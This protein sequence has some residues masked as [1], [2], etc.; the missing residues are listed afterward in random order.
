MTSQIANVSLSPQQIAAA[1]EIKNWYERGKEEG[2]E[3]KPI[4]R[5]FGYAG[6]GKTT[7][8]RFITE[9]L[10]IAEDILFAAYTGKAAMVMRKHGLPARTIHS[11]IYEPSPP[12]QNKCNELHK[13]L[14]EENDAGERKRIRQELKEASAVHFE[15]RD[16]RKSDLRDCPLLILDE[17]SMVNEDM[18][19]DLLTFRVPLLVLGDPGQLPPIEGTGA[20]IKEK[21]DIML[22]EIHRQAAGN[23]IIQ[24]SLRARNGIPIP[25]G[26][27]YNHLNQSSLTKEQ[28]FSYDQIL[29]GKNLTRIALNQRVRDVKQFEDKIY[30]CVGDRL[31]CLKNNPAIGLYNGLM[32][33]VIERGELLDSSIELTIKTEL[34]VIMEVKA[35]RAHFD[36]YYDKEALDS[37][38]WWERQDA[39]EFDF[40][41]CIT[42]HKAQGSQWDN[43]LLWDDKFFVWDRNNRKKWLYTGITRAAEKLTIASK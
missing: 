19:K 39:D 43:V 5:L 12:D 40:G 31:V 42:V 38:K 28:V 16:K 15:L 1:T 11:L 7:T 37:V 2:F 30:P 33:E 20:L 8:I 25:K 36:V 24:L 13:K 14:K 29:C 34:D 35:L 10:G 3:D 21:P 17:C 23:P 6:T 27:Q 26:E 22:T 18:L 32:C 4:F 9:Q 41:Y